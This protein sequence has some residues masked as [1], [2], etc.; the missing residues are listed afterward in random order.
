MTTDSRLDFA[1]KST[2][3]A[4]IILE[5]A[6]HSNFNCFSHSQSELLGAS[7]FS[8]NVNREQPTQLVLL[9]LSW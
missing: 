7:N 1:G 2:A 9:Q 4:A 3:A 5:N 6:N 8:K